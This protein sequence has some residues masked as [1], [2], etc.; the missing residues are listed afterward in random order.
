MSSDYSFP[1]VYVKDV[2]SYRY[3]CL[4]KDSYII[5]SNTSECW[6]TYGNIPYE[7][8]FKYI[9]L[10]EART[11]KPFIV[12]LHNEETEN[13]VKGVLIDKNTPLCLQE[14]LGNI[15]YF[16]HRD[17][18]RVEKN[19]VIAYI[20]TNKLEVRSVKSMCKGII[21]LTI[22]MP[23]EEPRKA[24]FVVVENEPRF[25]DIRKTTR[26]NV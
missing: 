8:S 23:W 26:S 1:E 10:V 14:V 25:I 9:D 17:G 15:I 12:V 18:V 16:L 19:N 4:N 6:E 21:M 22:D 3:I 20:I 7:E 11:I 13:T 5:T 24:L 2:S